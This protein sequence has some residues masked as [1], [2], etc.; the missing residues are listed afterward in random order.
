M[1]PRQLRA[2]RDHKSLAM[3]AVTA[4]RQQHI[5]HGEARANQGDRPRGRQALGRQVLEGLQGFFGRSR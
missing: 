2:A 5:D 1:R 3:K 4:G